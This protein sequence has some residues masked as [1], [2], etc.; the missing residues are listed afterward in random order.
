MRLCFHFVLER[1]LWLFLLSNNFDTFHQRLSSA[2]STGGP[3]F[4]AILNPYLCQQNGHLAF[5]SCTK[6]KVFLFLL[7]EF[8][9]TSGEE[10]FFSW[11]T[12][13]PLSITLDTE[14]K[15]FLNRG[16][17]YN[18]FLKLNPWCNL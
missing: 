13:C 18:L 8:F 11:T 3:N 10:I 12:L 1:E 16:F 17:I 7:L 6:L 9:C 5:G 15:I 4:C 2:Y 14:I